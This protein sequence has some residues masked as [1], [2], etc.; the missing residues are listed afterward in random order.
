MPGINPIIIHTT[1]W[2][3]YVRKH[4]DWN[5]AKA[6]NADQFLLQLHSEIDPEAREQLAG[7]IQGSFDL[8]DALQLDREGKQLERIQL[9]YPFIDA[10]VA[11]VP[12]PPEPPAGAQ[13]LLTW[14]CSPDR[15]E[16]TLGDAH[17]QFA[18]LAE[19]GPLPLAQARYWLTVV[20]AA[21]AF[22]GQLI[23]K[24]TGLDGLFRRLG[25]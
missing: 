18:V 25:S 5:G 19:R 11:Q 21:I 13:Y 3:A 8:Q 20:E 16:E 22:V 1:D 10:E 2:D 23:T 17:E 6:P 7:F 14:L 12:S 9:V 4:V 24:V 15:L